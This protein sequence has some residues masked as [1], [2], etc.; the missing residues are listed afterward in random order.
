LY[1]KRKE[2]RQGELCFELADGNPDTKIIMHPCHRLGGH[3]SWEHQ[4]VKELLLI[5]F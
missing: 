4:K 2:L 3:Q 5:T 1:T